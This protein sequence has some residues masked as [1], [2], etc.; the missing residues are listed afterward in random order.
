MGILIVKFWRPVWL[1][2]MWAKSPGGEA[3]FHDTTISTAFFRTARN[4]SKAM[5][6]VLLLKNLNAPGSDGT[7]VTSALM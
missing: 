4:V 5:N 2:E 6:F 3:R 1:V 7:C